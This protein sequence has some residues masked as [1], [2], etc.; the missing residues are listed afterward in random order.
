MVPVPGVEE[1]DGIVRTQSSTMNGAIIVAGSPRLQDAY[2]F[3]SW[4]TSAQAQ[5]AFG[6]QSEVLLGKSARY[7]TANRVAFEQ[8]NWTS[9]ERKTLAAA[10]E[11]VWDVEQTAATYYVG[12]CLTNAFRRVVYSYESPRDVLYRYNADITGELTRKQRQL[13]RQ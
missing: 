10:W 6:Q 7:N 2:Q 3:V 1:A 4:W 9:E 11:Q 13:S 12:R 5:T 8:L